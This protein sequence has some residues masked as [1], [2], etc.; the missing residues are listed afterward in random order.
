MFSHEV[1]PALA[2]LK[3][4]P[5]LTPYDKAPDCAL[6]P[7]IK[8]VKKLII[9]DILFIVLNFRPTKIIYFGD[10]SPKIQK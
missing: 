3:V 6:T 8:K 2:Q 9:N 1:E 5:A 7:T 10:I 4:G